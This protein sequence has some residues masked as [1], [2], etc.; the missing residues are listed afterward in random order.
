MRP[1]QGG[2][3]WSAEWNARGESP[4]GRSELK[5]IEEFGA[6]KNRSGVT[7]A[8]G[9]ASEP[10]GAIGPSDGLTIKSVKYFFKCA[11]IQPKKMS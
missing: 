6:L 7:D 10:A 5:N 4:K 1:G 2:A 3:Q 9:V 11:S 8:G